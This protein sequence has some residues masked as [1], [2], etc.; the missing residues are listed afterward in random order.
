[1]IEVGQVES[2]DQITKKTAQ[3]LKYIDINMRNA[4]SLEH[5]LNR[6]NM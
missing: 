4:F 5:S 1:M 6:L 2:S 3:S